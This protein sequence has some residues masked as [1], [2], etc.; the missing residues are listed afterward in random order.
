MNLC[1][2]EISTKATQ[3]LLFSDNLRLLFNEEVWYSGS[4]VSGINKPLTTPALDNTESD[5][6]FKK[7]FLAAWTQKWP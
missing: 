5:S 3:Y 1:T 7:W 2:W 6:C 4:V